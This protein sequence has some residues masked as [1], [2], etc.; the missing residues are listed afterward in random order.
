MDRIVRK[1]ELL[2]RLGVSDNFIWRAEKEGK[3][4]KRIQLGDCSVGWMA[5][6]IDAYFESKK[7]ER[8]GQTPVRTPGQRRSG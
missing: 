5:S 6:E 3:F 7:A 1:P 2:E 8:D 4:P